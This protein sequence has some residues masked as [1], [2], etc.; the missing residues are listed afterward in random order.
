MKSKI[1]TH[2]ILTTWFSNQTKNKDGIQQRKNTLFLLY[3]V[4][5]KK[6]LAD[7]NLFNIFL[8]YFA[9][10]F[11]FWKTYDLSQKINKMK[12]VC[13]SLF[14]LNKIAKK[15]KKIYDYTE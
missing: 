15:K 1:I 10:L 6:L 8:K 9:D 3:V 13:R 2:F 4:S 11:Q 7:S 12:S 14:C 5:I